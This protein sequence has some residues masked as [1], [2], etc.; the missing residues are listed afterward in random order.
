MLSEKSP[1]KHEA[2]SHVCHTVP[3]IRNPSFQS[4]TSAH[5]L[6]LPTS[7]GSHPFQLDPFGNTLTDIPLVGGACFQGVSKCSPSAMRMD[8]CGFE[9]QTLGK[10]DLYIQSFEI[11][12]LSLTLNKNQFKWGLHIRPK[13]MNLLIKIFEDIEFSENDSSRSGNNSKS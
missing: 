5:E 7:K 8:D 4:G 3:R 10:Q 11:P 12:S 1:Q 13:M 2:A 6:V 9:K